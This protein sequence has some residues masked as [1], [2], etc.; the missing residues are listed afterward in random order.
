VERVAVIGSGGA[1]KTTFARALGARTGLDVVHLDT[2]FWKPGWVPTPPDDWR[3]LQA[4]LVDRDRWIIDG[5]FT[6]TLDIRLRVA[7]TVVFLD[8]PRRVCLRRALWRVVRDHGKATEA[9][10]CPESFDAAFTR[11]IWTY[12]RQTRP[13]VMDAIDRHA[14][15]ASVVV[16][17]RPRD[18]SR[19]LDD[20]GGG[21]RQMAVG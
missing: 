8:F 16:L 3:A 17:G 10:G 2:F 19:Y 4:N 18:A 6:S 5:N 15:G 9:E 20:V 14:A 21:S 11:W 1:G 13:M 12:R 7:D